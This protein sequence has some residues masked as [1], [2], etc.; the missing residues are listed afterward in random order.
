MRFLL[1]HESF[2]KRYTDEGRKRLG[3]VTM[4]VYSMILCVCLCATE[5]ISELPIFQRI[6]TDDRE[7]SLPTDSRI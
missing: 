3:R 5:L 1:D 2:K 7:R 6:Y 4:D